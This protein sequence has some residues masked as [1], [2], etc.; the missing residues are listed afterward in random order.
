[1]R[2]RIVAYLAVVV[3]ALA[4]GACEQPTDLDHDGVVDKDDNCLVVR[5]SDQQDADGDGQGDACD[6]L[7]DSDGDGVAD[8]AD[9]CPAKANRDQR[10]ADGDGQG[11]ACDELTDR[12]G[13]GVA[14]DSDNCPTVSNPQQDDANGDGVGDACDGVA[15]GDGDGVADGADNCPTVSNPNQRDTDGDGIGD[16]CDVLTD[17]DGDGVP[18]ASDN[19]PTASNPDQRD[20]DGDGIGDACDAFNDRDADGVEDQND[21]CPAAANPAQRDSDGD[22]VG[23]A[24]DPA[25]ALPSAGLLRAEVGNYSSHSA[26]FTLDLF[27]VGPDSLRYSL[28]PGDFSIASFELP[29][30]PGARHEFEQQ[31]TT[32]TRQSAVGAYSAALLVEQSASISNNDPNDARL[33]AAATFIDNLASG[34]EVGL[35]AY[36]TNGSLPFSPVTSYGDADGNRFTMDRDGFDSAL[37]SLAA[38]EGGDAALYDALRIAI[39]FTASNAN[40]THRAVVVLTDGNDTNNTA[41]VAEVIDYANQQRV[42]LHMVGLANSV[43]LAVLTQLAAGTGG[44]I[45]SASDARQL[46]SYYGALGPFLTGSGQFYRTTWRLNIVGGRLRLYPGYWIRTSVA[47]DTPGGTVRVPFRL[48]FN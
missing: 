23:D 7:T 47:I 44:S 31:G 43:D 11:D 20:S 29:Q 21:N 42:T 9:N 32:L 16:A 40:N 30:S 15:D 14:D 38:L 4:I 2:L 19:C 35:L 39:H 24:C 36:A 5:N 22:G 45:S 10:D 6:I 18:D 34:S 26:E 8:H 25:T 46:I 28:S 17:G 1:M 41:S 37:Q 12:D 48:D 33:A 27:A 3:L 13:D